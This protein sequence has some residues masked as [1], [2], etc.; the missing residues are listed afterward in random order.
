MHKKILPFLSAFVAVIVLVLTVLESSFYTFDALLCDRLYTKMDGMNPKIKII[1]VDEETLEE[2]GNFQVWSR[3]K[4][5][6]LHQAPGDGKNVLV[7]A[8]ER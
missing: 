8:E 5:A 7:N 6:D 1:A 3:E 2:Y 4:T